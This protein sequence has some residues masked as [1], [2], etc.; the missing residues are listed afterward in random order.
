[1]DEYWL[2]SSNKE[3]AAKK[4]DEDMDAYWEKK[5]QPAT[6]EDG[7]T[8]EQAGEKEDETKDEKES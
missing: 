1:M 6:K 8:E 4:L 7:E 5:G 3:V 2:K